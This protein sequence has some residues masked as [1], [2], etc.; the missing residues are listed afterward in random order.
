VEVVVGGSDGG[1]R[2][3]RTVPVGGENGVGEEKGGRE[4]VFGD[5]GEMI[6]WRENEVPAPVPVGAVGGRRAGG[7]RTGLGGKFLEGG[8]EICPVLFVFFEQFDFVFFFFKKMKKK[9]WHVPHRQ[10]WGGE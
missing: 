3:G 9:T 6:W 4:R 5:G 10:R 8:N 1:E 7:G 2:R